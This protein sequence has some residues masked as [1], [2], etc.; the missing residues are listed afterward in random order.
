MRFSKLILTLAVAIALMAYAVDCSS[1]ST[2]QEAMQCCASMHCMPHGHDGQDCCKAMP[3]MRASLAQ[4]S[5]IIGIS[6]AKVVFAIVPIST[7]SP[8]NGSSAGFVKAQWHA[9]PVL[10]SPIPHPLLI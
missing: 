7:E 4:P 1:M 10:N 2:P 9:P 6:F 3:E 5:S 8:E